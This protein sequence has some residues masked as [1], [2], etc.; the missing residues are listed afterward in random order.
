M[1]GDRGWRGQVPNKEVSYHERNVQDVMIGDFQRQIAELTQLLAAQ[2]M[3]M[4]RDID[5]HNSESNFENPYHNPGSGTA[6]S[7]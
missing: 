4:Y 3:L 6:W 5:D 1:T 2:N 7:G